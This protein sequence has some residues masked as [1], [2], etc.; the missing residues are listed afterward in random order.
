MCCVV[1]ARTEQDSELCFEAAVHDMAKPCYELSIRYSATPICVDDV[2]QAA[3]GCANDR[4]RG[5]EHQASGL[6]S[7]VKAR[8]PHRWLP[9]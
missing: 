6:G 5:H 7:I 3:R 8:P 4:M 9:T 1:R 2:E